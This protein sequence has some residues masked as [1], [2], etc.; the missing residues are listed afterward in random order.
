LQGRRVYNASFNSSQSLFDESVSVGNIANGIYLL[1]TI[2][3]NRS[4]TKRIII[5]K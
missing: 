1:K 5:S 2:Q 4:T 3:G